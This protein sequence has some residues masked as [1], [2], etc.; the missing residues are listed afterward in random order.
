MA[1]LTIERD[2]GF[3]T[4]ILDR[5]K[6]MNALSRALRLELVAIMAELGKDDSVRAII[7]TGRG[8]RAFSAGADLKELADVEPGFRT[9]REEDDPV[10][11]ISE[12][13]KPVIAAVNGFAITGGLELMLACD[14]LIASTSARFADTH[15]RVGILPGWGLSQRLPL[16]IGPSR[17][18]E[19]SLTGN[20]IAAETA[21]EWGLVNRLVSPVDLLP[22]A[23]KIA[24][25]IVSGDPRAVQHYKQTI[26]MGLGLPLEDGLA[27]ERRRAAAWLA[28]SAQSQA[29]T[30]HEENQ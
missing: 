19:M 7:L 6:A 25:D 8:E 30:E 21:L 26:D 5:P 2:E 24:A 20:Y 1:N 29:A 13:P 15:V 16:L 28:S 17:A 22:E 18:K 10:R 27:L 3:V 4:I 14:I 9:I 23:R 12:C 11:A